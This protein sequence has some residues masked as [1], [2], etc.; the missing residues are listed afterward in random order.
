MHVQILQQDT[1]MMC[2]W[3]CLLWGSPV[4]LLVACASLLWLSVCLSVYSDRVSLCSP[5]WP[6]THHPP[7]SDSLGWDYR[8]RPHIQLS[9][10]SVNTI[11][12]LDT[13]H[14]SGVTMG[15]EADKVPW[16]PHGVQNT[17]EKAV[18][19]LA[20]WVVS[21][22]G[23]LLT[24]QVALCWGFPWFPYTRAALCCWLWLILSKTDLHSHAFWASVKTSFTFFT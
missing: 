13:S 3:G 21:V 12:Y 16:H 8:W 2:P 4:P 5:D 10:C 9:V 6:W 15:S 1:S 22:W 18:F 11:S 17:E 24:P 7:A 14:C 23:F 20:F 19:P